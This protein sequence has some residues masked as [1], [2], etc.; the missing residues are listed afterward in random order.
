LQV[1]ANFKRKLLI[2]INMPQKDNLFMD[3]VMVYHKKEPYF[4]TWIKTDSFLAFQLALSW[5][6][7]PR[8]CSQRFA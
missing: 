2:K 7:N 1:S 3:F 8:R 4:V 5:C 6:N